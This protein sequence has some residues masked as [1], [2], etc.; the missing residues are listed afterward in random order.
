MIE[1][2]KLISSRLKTVLPRVYFLRASKKSVFPYLVYTIEIT[3]IEDD[4]KLLTLDVDG[5]DKNE[6]TTAL[7]TLM[8]SV[9]NLFK[10]ETII[11]EKMV[12]S[13]HSDRRLP[14]EDDD[15]TLNRRKN[16]YLGRL[17]ER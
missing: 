11:T 4:V 13:F 2:R 10:N 7:E 14:V 16:I 15:Q 1:I 9:H 17:Y 3:D 6:D 5:W 8:E 12:I